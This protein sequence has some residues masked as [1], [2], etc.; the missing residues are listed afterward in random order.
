MY[1][2]ESPGDVSDIFQGKLK[3]WMSTIDLIEKFLKHSFVQFEHMGRITPWNMVCANHGFVSPRDNEENL[4]RLPVYRLAG[5]SNRNV[6]PDLIHDHIHRNRGRILRTKGRFLK[7]TIHPC[8]STVN[9]Q[10]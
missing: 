9:Y 7:K 10:F 6:R 1:R 2:Q 4:R 8:T 5:Q 3:R